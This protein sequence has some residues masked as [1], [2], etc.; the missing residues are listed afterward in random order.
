M[1]TVA[2]NNKRIAKNTIYLYIRLLFAMAV[3]LY[4]SRVVLATLGAD[5][6][7]LNAVVT[8]AITIFFF[9]NSSMA[10]ATSRFLTFEIG[11]GDT[12]K[13]KKT[14]S[15][16]LTIHIIIA[17][18]ILILG[19]TVGLW[20]LEN[21]MVVPEG[22]MTAAR[23]V[24]HLSL[25]SAM[26]TITQV[27]Y[28]ASIMSHEK[29]NVYA[30]I[31]ITKTLLQ[32]GIV[33]LLVIGNIDKL[34]LYAILTL[35]VTIVVTVIYRI[36]CIKH[37]EECK[38]KFEWDKKVIKPMLS[39]SGWNLYAEAGLQVSSQGI[40]LVLNLFF[41]TVVNAAYSIGNQVGTVLRQ[42]ADNFT[43]ASNP[44][45]V[46]YYAEGKIKEMQN[47][48]ENSTKFAFL[49]YFAICLPVMLEIDFVLKLWLNKVPEYT[50][51]FTQLSI[52]L[53]LIGVWAFTT[54]TT[55]IRA[56]GKIITYSIMVGTLRTITPIVA[57]FLFKFT[58]AHVSVP[59]II[60]IVV[61][62]LI[63]IG[64]FLIIKK[65]IPTFAVWHYFKHVILM[66]C[67]VA[68]I[69]SVIPILM[70]ITIEEGLIRFILVVFSSIISMALVSYFMVL[71]KS[72][73]EKVKVK[74]MT[75]IK[76]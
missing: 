2:E 35:C 74:I 65:Q 22:R 38:Y 63:L 9:L 5:D 44:Q 36:Y 28:N 60:S 32:L 73:Q 40:Q 43:T 50:N 49:M 24:Y 4:T 39:F 54:T 33:F 42:F 55:T 17:I 7:G 58:N 51:L 25:V 67:Y 62:M 75:V 30:Y 29:M 18:I 53:L 46:K 64:D 41:S 14:F 69:V 37:F 70:R 68:V 8:S 20:Y 31:E 71:S 15:A 13:L 21:K 12:D 10:G 3:G 59:V 26:L 47:L 6:F 76:K 34:I 72:M 23:W 16:A 61:V 11:K 19:E 52:V 27:P 45:I 66:N 56:T 1:S 57:Y 48:V